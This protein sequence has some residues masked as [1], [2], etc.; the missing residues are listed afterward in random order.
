MTWLYGEHDHWFRLPKGN[1]HTGCYNAA[2]QLVWFH[3]DEQK[4][5][6]DAAQRNNI[7]LKR[8]CILS[9]AVIQCKRIIEKK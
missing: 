3:I 7:T 5:I 2:S 1:V 6:D 4:G 8:T 9:K